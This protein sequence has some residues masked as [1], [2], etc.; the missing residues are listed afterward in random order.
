MAMNSI[1]DAMGGMAHGPAPAH[2]PGK[3]GKP[4]MG[5][6]ESGGHYQIHPH[7]DGSAHSMTP[8]GQK[9]EHPSMHHAAAHMLGHH[10]SGDGHSVVHHHAEGGHT[11]HHAHEG[12]V[13]GPHEHQDLEG[14]KDKMA[15][16]SGESPEGEG[17]RDQFDHE[18]A[19]AGSGL[20]G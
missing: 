19:S 1:S 4:A 8:D 10:N 20:F 6:A 16:T 17:G 12:A 9:M 7:E 14:V 15:E 18:P 5:G 3:M 13:N 2:Q 11:S